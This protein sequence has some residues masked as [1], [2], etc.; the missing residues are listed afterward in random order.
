MSMAIK[1]ENFISFF[2]LLP[3]AFPA[4]LHFYDARIIHSFVLGLARYIVTLYELFAK[5]KRENESDTAREEA[6]KKK[7]VHSF[8]QSN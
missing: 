2:F 7:R 4:P 5:R 8:F 3:D 6:N 1:M